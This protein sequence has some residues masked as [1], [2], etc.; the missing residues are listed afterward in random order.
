M[1]NDDSALDITQAD[2]A[3]DDDCMCGAG[4][5]NDWLSAEIAGTP[6][7]GPAQ[8]RVVVGVARSTAP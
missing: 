1:C 3:L 6:V 7:N 8:L 2:E 4:G 5:S